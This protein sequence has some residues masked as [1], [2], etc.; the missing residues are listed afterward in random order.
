MKKNLVSETLKDTQLRA[1]KFLSPKKIAVCVFC[2]LITAFIILLH[3]FKL[4]DELTARNVYLVRL[5]DSVAWITGGIFLN[6]IFDFVLVITLRGSKRAVTIE[7]MLHSCIKYVVGIAIIVALLIVWLGKAYV[8][9]V[10]GGLGILALIIGFGAQKLISDIIAG[11]FMVFEA[12]IAVGDVIT[13]GDFRGVVQEIG[14]RTTVLV[15]DGGNMKVMNNSSISEFINMSRNVSY[16]S[17]TCLLDYDED[18]ERAEKIIISALPS[19]K[20]KIP[21]ILCEPE[22]KGVDSLSD[23]GYKLKI[24]AKCEEENIFQTQRALNRELLLLCKSEN[25]RLAFPQLEV[26][27]KQ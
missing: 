11:F 20:E 25:V 21:T 24:V 8:S 15:S 16:A 23:S 18:L 5:I 10:L 26:R 6:K 1:K 3:T 9:E 14:L 22:Y 4:L 7:I 27:N 17:C 12:H 19:L 2:F 13:I